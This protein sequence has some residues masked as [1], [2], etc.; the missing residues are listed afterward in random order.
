[1]FPPRNFR[2]PRQCTVMMVVQ[3]RTI[4]DASPFVPR[5]S[6]RLRSYLYRRPCPPASC[7]PALFQQV[8]YSLRTLFSKT[9]PALSPTVV[10]ST[11]VNR[12]IVPYLVVLIRVFCRRLRI[13]AL[14]GRKLGSNLSLL[15]YGHA[16]W[17]CL[18]L[19][20]PWCIVPSLHGKTTP[21]ARVTN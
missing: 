8:G 19:L 9:R 7:H 11:K 2:P 1:V 14:C 10:S 15:Y 20:A 12:C 4:R 5:S 21:S 6:F 17:A 18:R 16:L 3:Y 13:G